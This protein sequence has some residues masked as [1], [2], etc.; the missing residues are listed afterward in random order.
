MRFHHVVFATVLGFAL[1][2]PG[3]AQIPRE[4]PGAARVPRESQYAT[5]RQRCAAVLA[6]L[7]PGVTSANAT[8]L[9][10][11]RDCDQSAGPFLARLW[12]APQSDT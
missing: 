6:D 5:T 9:Y 7:A 8:R 12:S 10:D 4:S 1:S 2:L 3:A 11:L